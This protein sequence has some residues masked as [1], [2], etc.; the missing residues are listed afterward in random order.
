MLKNGLNSLIF[1]IKVREKYAASFGAIFCSDFAR[2]VSKDFQTL[3]VFL[4]YP[5]PPGCYYKS[6]KTLE[7]IRK[8]FE[9]KRSIENECA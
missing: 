1:F 2:F 3:C 5:S 4:I 9:K 8:D 7:R 6:L